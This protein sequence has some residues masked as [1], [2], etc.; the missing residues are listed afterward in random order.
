MINSSTCDI[1][2]YIKWL[3]LACRSGAPSFIDEM[4][5]PRM[6]TTS[7]SSLTILLR[8]TTCEEDSG[9]SR[10]V[11]DTSFVTNSVGATCDSKFVSYP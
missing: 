5:P 8:E 1:C 11:D 10:L 7:D 6:M 2:V 3:E 9:T 4:S